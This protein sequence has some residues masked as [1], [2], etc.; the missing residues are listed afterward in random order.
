MHD[1]MKTRFPAE[2]GV[3]A[4]CILELSPADR[5]HAYERLGRLAREEATRRG[6]S[7]YLASDIANK[8]VERQQR[9]VEILEWTTTGYSRFPGATETNPPQQAIPHR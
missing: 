6:I 3:Q 9:L 8:V 5:E 4:H 1:G 2:A 7:A